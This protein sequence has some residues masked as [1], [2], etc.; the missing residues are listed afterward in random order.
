MNKHKIVEL[1][2]LV[3]LISPVGYFTLN[4][5]LFQAAVFSPFA[6]T[7]F[8]HLLSKSNDDK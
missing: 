7:Y 2:F 3:L 4:G 1:A 8:Q 6:N 5:Q